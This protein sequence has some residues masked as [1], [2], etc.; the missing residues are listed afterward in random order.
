MVTVLTA[1]PSSR[2]GVPAPTAEK[3]FKRAPERAGRDKRTEAT[4]SEYIRVQYRPGGI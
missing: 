1:E 4:V 3:A 2:T